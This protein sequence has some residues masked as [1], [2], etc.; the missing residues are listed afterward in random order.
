MYY[1]CIEDK[2]VIS[3]LNYEPVVP[4]TV[5]VVEIPN[6]SAEKISNQTHYFNTENNR[7][8]PVPGE[9]L[10]KKAQEIENSLHREFLNST[11]WKVLRHIRE[12]ALEIDTTLSEDD[13]K[14]LEQQRA[15]AA[16]KIVE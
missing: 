1:V 4:E 10:D 13:Y 8:E 6:S 5:S 2:K 12:K 3:I 9:F 14:A 11:D 16:S 15:D 7:V